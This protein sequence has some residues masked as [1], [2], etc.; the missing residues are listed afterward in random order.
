MSPLFLFTAKYSFE[1]ELKRNTDEFLN[2]DSIG[3]EKCN[4]LF[5]LLLL[6]LFDNN[7]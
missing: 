5:L 1:L 3:L 4:N 7:N 2:V 6:L